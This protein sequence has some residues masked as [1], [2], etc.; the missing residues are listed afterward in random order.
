MPDRRGFLG[1]VA[2][3]AG[4]CLGWKPAEVPQKLYIAGH[5]VGIGP[6][7]GIPYWIV[8]IPVRGPAT[9]TNA[10]AIAA[11]EA[12]DAEVSAYLSAWAKAHA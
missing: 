8:K 2:A 7:S 1:A 10:E 4:F 3:A 12:R 6:L 9:Y 11:I 5:D